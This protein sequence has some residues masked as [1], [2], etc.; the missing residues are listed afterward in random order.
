MSN[1]KKMCYVEDGGC[2]NREIVYQ[3]QTFKKNN[4]GF[5]YKCEHCGKLYEKKERW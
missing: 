4:N 1:Y 5:S 3:G 2:G